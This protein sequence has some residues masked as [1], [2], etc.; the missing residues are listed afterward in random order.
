M[1]RF[2]KVFISLFILC[3]VVG[4]QQKSQN[5][6]LEKDGE[7]YKIADQVSFY[8]PKDYE[9]DTSNDN[10]KLIQFIKD[11]EVLQYSTS[12]DDTDNKIEDLP[13]LYEGQLEED[14]AGDIHY[15]KVQ[16]DSGIDCYEFMGNYIATGVKFKHVVYFTTDATYIYAYQS[17]EESYDENI[18]V[19]TQYLESLTV[20]HEV[21]SSLD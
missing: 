18:E 4:C 11:E 5:V 16:L 8:Y 13:K 12:I 21:S 2:L 3:F 6:F 1:R 9:V 10:K 14:G 7:L 15:Y 19:I 20:H 17:P